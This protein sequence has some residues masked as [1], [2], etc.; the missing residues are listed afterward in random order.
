MGETVRFSQI[1]REDIRFG[2]NAFEVTLASGQV[3]LFNEVDVGYVLA[4]LTG[5][6]T[7]AA[8]TDLPAV[9]SVNPGR[10]AR[11]S[12]DGKIYFDTGTA[13]VAIGIPTGTTG[14]ILFLTSTGIA[15]DNSNL[16]W[17][18][19][20]NRLGVGTNTNLNEKINLPNLGYIAGVNAAG[21]ATKKLI[22]LNASDAIDIG[23]GGT[24]VTLNGALTAAQGVTIPTGKTLTIAD[25]TQNG[26]V[27]GGASGVVSYTGAPTNGQVLIGY[28][29]QAPTLATLTEGEGIDITNGPG[30]ITIA[31]PSQAAYNRTATQLAIVSTA[32]ET[33]IF[34]FTVNANDLSTNKALH[35]E[36]F[37]DY[38]NNSGAGRTLQLKIKYG[39]TTLFDDVSVSLGASAVRQAWRLSLILANQSSTSSQVLIGRFTLSEDAGAAT[40]GLG[41]L[42]GPDPISAT[43]FGTSAINTALNA[44]F[45]VTF[46]HSA[47]NAN[48]EIRRQYAN[49]VLV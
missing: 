31:A 29:G 14:S 42:T 4:A 49:V 21:N 43:I 16:F 38:L 26:I 45:D 2:R 10:I 18:D 30:T 39:A 35:I 7:Y 41:D 19:T 5:L 27:Y 3:V 48:L 17:D 9:D 20:N 34:S 15:Q 25:L 6:R 40:T 47:S 22:G 11:V 24:A 32:S 44:T 37:G 46:Q 1:G 33:S 23:N 28:T 13:W 8:T 36:L 12:A